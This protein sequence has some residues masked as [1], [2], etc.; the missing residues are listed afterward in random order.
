M[1]LHVTLQKPKTSAKKWQGKKW[2]S[3]GTPMQDTVYHRDNMV[4]HMTQLC[5]TKVIH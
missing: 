3:Q 1:D 4:M 5:K 2:L